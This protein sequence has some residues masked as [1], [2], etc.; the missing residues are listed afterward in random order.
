LYGGIDK[1]HTEFYSVNNEL[2]FS[3]IEDTEYREPVG[4]SPYPE[5]AKATTDRYYFKNGQLILWLRNK[6]KQD[7]NK[8]LLAGKEIF[9]NYLD[10]L[11]KREKV[12]F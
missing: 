11:T 3:Y 6:K 10:F 8:Y 1:I 12:L 2:T 4:S 9:T 7:Y 5:I